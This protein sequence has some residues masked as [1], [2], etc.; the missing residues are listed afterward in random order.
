MK[1]PSSV[2]LQVKLEDSECIISVRCTGSDLADQLG[3]GRLYLFGVIEV[4][5]PVSTVDPTEVELVGL[6]GDLSWGLG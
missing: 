3:L 5:F 6:L 2:Q 1:K 4:R